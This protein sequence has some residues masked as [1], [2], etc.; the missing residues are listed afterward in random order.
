MTVF[1]YFPAKEDLVMHHISDHGSRFA[2]IVRNRAHGLSPLGALRED[3]LAALTA[4]DPFAGLSD[5]RNFLAFYKMLGDT[6]PATADQRTE[7]GPGSRPYRRVL[8]DP[9]R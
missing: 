8:R 1:N 6:E 3:F 7:A 9:D 2:G 4:H 5:D